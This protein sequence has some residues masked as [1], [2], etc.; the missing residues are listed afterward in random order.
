M[1][2][3]IKS[4]PTSGGLL[5]SSNQLLSSRVRRTFDYLPEHLRLLTDQP[6]PQQ[7]ADRRSYQCPETQGSLRTEHLYKAL[8]EELHL[9]DQLTRSRQQQ[10]VQMVQLRCDVHLL[11]LTDV[12]LMVQRPNL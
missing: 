3:V 11:L 4:R 5:T 7:L 6:M 9:L 1:G 2:R 12:Y 10:L 8:A